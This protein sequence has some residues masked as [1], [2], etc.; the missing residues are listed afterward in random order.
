MGSA[1]LPPPRQFLLSV[2]TS[3]PGSREWRPGTHIQLACLPVSPNLVCDQPPG[4]NASVLLGVWIR[5]QWHGSYFTLSLVETP[6]SLSS[7]AIL[8][9]GVKIKPSTSVVSSSQT[10]I[11][12]YV[13]EEITKELHFLVIW[14]RSFPGHPVCTLGCGSGGKT[15]SPAQITGTMSEACPLV[16]CRHVCSL[17]GACPCQV[18]GLSLCFW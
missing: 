1:V 2:W 16:D 11:P 12:A 6:S 4:N 14:A 3:A 15:H 7:V 17:C 9:P 13:W 18:C 8:S 5:L 10:F